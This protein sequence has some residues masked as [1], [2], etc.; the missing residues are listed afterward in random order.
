M[1][2]ENLRYMHYMTTLKSN[3]KKLQNMQHCTSRDETKQMKDHDTAIKGKVWP[4]PGFLKNDFRY[5]MYKHL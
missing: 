3:G 1:K 2:D 4:F 5:L